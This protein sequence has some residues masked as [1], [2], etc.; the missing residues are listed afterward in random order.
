MRSVCCSLAFD[1][2]NDCFTQNPGM[3]VSF[4]M[5]TASDLREQT[6]F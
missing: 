6:C 3:S 4:G 1:Q 5:Q 2:D